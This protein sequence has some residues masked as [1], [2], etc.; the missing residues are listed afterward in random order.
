MMAMPRLFH[1]FCTVNSNFVPVLFYIAQK[2]K[3]RMVSMEIDENLLT[4]NELS[5]ISS[6][7]PLID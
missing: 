3:E 7:M 5:C 6:T 4:K 1:L 2:G